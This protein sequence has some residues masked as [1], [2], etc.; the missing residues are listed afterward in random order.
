MTEIS[1]YE[2]ERLTAAEFR[3]QMK[4][5]L[6]YCVQGGVVEIDRMGQTFIV[7]YQ[8]RG[9]HVVRMSNPVAE[10]RIKELAEHHPDGGSVIKIPFTKK[11]TSEPSALEGEF[12]VAVEAGKSIPKCCTLKNPCKHWQFDSSKELWVNSI[13]GATREV[14]Q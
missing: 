1:S 11:I 6:D 5:A 2:P 14:E 13:T 12:D 7:M 8:G 10:N 3:K 4:M 9:Q